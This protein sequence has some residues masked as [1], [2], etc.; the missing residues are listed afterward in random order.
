[1]A[2]NPDDIV[3]YEFKQALRG[4][5]ISEVDDLLDRL[6]D[7]VERDER[8]RDEL[9]QRLRD[10]E[11]RLAS[12]LETESTLKRTL[13]IAQQAADRSMADALEQAD[14]LRVA[15]EREVMEQ[16]RQANAEADRIVGD[17]HR[18]ATAELDAA[19]R[20]LAD[21]S[22]RLVELR[23]LNEGHL[24]YM[25]SYLSE[26]LASLDQ[27]TP[28]SPAVDQPVSDH[29]QQHH[30][31]QDYAQQDYA[32]QDDAQYDD[33]APDDAE[34]RDAVLHDEHDAEQPISA[35][36]EPIIGTHDEG[37]DDW[38]LRDPLEP[39]RDRGSWDGD[40][41]A[42]A[43]DDTGRLTI[44]VRDEPD[45]IDVREDHRVGNGPDRHE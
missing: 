42:G 10:T 15:S 26:Q 4:Y 27:L 7:Q 24:R 13:I 45:H 9:R 16:L 37:S 17:A 22:A 1:M 12:A 44:R 28:I 18:T 25:R 35:R 30:A 29:A 23:D 6:A 41:D 34:Q 19:R 11:A 8:D 14:E 32:Q 3:S 31:Q 2:L 33:A 43:S 21:L 5:A 36:L 40:A 38:D 39:W 20:E